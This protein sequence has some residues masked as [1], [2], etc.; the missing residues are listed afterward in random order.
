[1]PKQKTKLTA[2]IDTATG[3]VVNIQPKKAKKKAPRMDIKEPRKAGR[4]ISV[5]KEARKLNK[6]TLSKLSNIYTAMLGK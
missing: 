6:P 2:K 1:M 4:P 5:V 3:K